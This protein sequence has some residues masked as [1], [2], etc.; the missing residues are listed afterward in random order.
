MAGHRLQTLAGCFA[1]LEAVHLDDLELI[2]DL[3]PVRFRL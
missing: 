3:R 2:D 1:P